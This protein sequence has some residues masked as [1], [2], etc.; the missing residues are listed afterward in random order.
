MQHDADE[1]ALHGGDQQHDEQRGQP[2][3]HAEAPAQGQV[4]K[5]MKLRL[6]V[7]WQG[8]GGRQVESGKIGTDGNVSR[9][10]RE[11]F[12]TIVASQP[13]RTHA[14]PGEFSTSTMPN[15]KRPAATSGCSGNTLQAH[16]KVKQPVQAT[17]QA[18][19]QRRQHP[20]AL[21]V[22]RFTVPVPN[23]VSQ[24]QRLELQEAEAL[25]RRRN[26]HVQI[27]VQ[28]VLAVRQLHRH[29]ER[30]I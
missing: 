8:E 27:K 23:V 20:A 28:A 7:T 12:H 25:P 3:Q 11:R 2:R 5:R 4:L 16:G 26:A 10:R 22:H 19:A 15:R 21:G 13:E 17:R 14:S 18:S 29:A 1:A 9:T 6:G 24:T 30:F